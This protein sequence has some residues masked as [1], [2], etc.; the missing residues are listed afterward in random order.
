MAEFGS[1]V[2]ELRKKKGLSIEK[3]AEQANISSSYWSQIETGA[4]N[5]PSER[6]VLRISETLDVPANVLAA[7]EYSYLFNREDDETAIKLAVFQSKLRNISSEATEL[8]AKYNWMAKTESAGNIAKE[9]EEIIQT[10][11]EK[12][13]PADV[14]LILTEL[15]FLDKRGREYVK[16]QIGLYRRLFLNKD[17]SGRDSGSP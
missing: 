1:L 8:T 14:Q 10:L 12:I 13:Y 16:D 5:P 2:R 9:L 7:T 17:H 15:L 3:A 6:I 11:E 4:K